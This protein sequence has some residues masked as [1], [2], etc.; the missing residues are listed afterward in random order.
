M[1]RV[2]HGGWKVWAIWLCYIAGMHVF[3]SVTWL[4]HVCDVTHSPVWHDSL[5]CVTWLIHKCDMTHSYVWR[6]SSYVWH[7][8]FIFATW[9]IYTCAMTGVSNVTC[10]TEWVVSH[11]NESRHVTHMNE[12]CLFICVTWLIH[13]CDMT[14]LYMCHHMWMSRVTCEWI[15]SFI[16][17]TYEWVM[18]HLWMSHVWHDS[19]I[20]DVNVN[21]SWRD[22]FTSRMSESCDVIHSHTCTRRRECG[23]QYMLRHM[24]HVTHMNGSCHAY[25][26]VMSRVSTS[27][28]MNESCHAYQWAMPRISMHHVTNAD[29]GAWDM[30]DVVRNE[31]CHMWISHATG[32][33]VMS[34]IWTSHV[35]RAGRRLRGIQYMVRQ[36]G[37]WP[38]EL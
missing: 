5:I 38:L 7:C 31:W 33:W 1:C 22:S 13:I 26:R 29:W 3:T 18:S 16:H 25:Q 21:E 4:I 10:S 36:M 28:V 2:T 24:T 14:H 23:R 11:V 35:I 9:L 27:H 6:D 34:H 8:S 12:S 30:Y 20:R 17:V 15:T 32:E 19:L 37:G